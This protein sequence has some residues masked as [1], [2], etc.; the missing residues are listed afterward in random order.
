MM[1]GNLSTSLNKPKLP[2]LADIERRR[3]ELLILAGLHSQH[4]A[5]PAF[6]DPASPPTSVLPTPEPLP[7]F[8]LL[9]PSAETE[10]DEEPA[11]S[12]VE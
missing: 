11:L 1:I 12:E 6:P 5:S 7:A 4:P 10:P 3:H 2:T 9:R 8:A